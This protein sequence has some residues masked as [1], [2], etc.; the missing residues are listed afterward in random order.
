M[1][2]FYILVLI[3]AAS[4]YSDDEHHEH[5]SHSSEHH[6]EPVRGEVCTTA[7]ILPHPSDCTKF[8]Y[9][10]EVGE[11]SYEFECPPGLFFNVG[12]LGYCGKT[13]MV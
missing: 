5:S 10:E 8:Y 3:L 7:G 11:L 6:S 9:C 4:V 13:C 2:L 1:K 12:T